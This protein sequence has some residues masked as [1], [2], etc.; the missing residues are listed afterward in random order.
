MKTLHTLMAVILCVAFVAWK[1]APLEAADATELP[2]LKIVPEDA[3]AIVVVSRLDRVDERLGKLGSE[4]QLPI[5]SLLPLLKSMSGVH[6]GLDEKSSAVL[7]I[8]PPAADGGSSV[9]VKLVPVSDYEKFLGQFH[10][11]TVADGIAEVILM[12]QPVVIGHK[13][14]FAVVASKTDRD[15]LKSVLASSRSLAPLV[16]PLAGWIGDHEI[17]F[18]A[19]PKGVKQGTAFA[20]NG[21]RQVKEALANSNDPSVKMTTSSLELYE[22][23]LEAAEKE[24]GELALGARI[25]NDGGLHLDI[26]ALF[27]AGGS[28]A[29]AGQSLEHPEGARLA[30][31]PNGPF[32]M[33]FDGPMPKAFSKN[34]LNLS[35]DMINTMSKTA[36]GKELNADQAK[37]LNDLMDKSMRNIRSMSMAMGAPKPGGS[38]Y[39]NTAAVMKV[40]DARKYIDDYQD[41]MAK[42][43][44]LLTASGVRMP[45][46]QEV[47][48]VKIDGDDAIQLTMDLAAMFNGMPQNPASKK[49]LDLMFGPG[50]KMTAYLAPI[51]EATVAMSY[52]N[53]DNIARIKAACKN[54]TSSLSA[55]SQ[56]AKT[57]A[58]LPEKA[59]WVGYVSPQGFMDFIIAAMKAAAP[60]GATVPPLTAFPETPPIGIGA[61]LS[62]QGFDLQVVVPGATVKG[63][64]SYIRQM[65][66]LGPPP[67]SAPPKE[68]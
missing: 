52:I 21:L 9:L 46:V 63:L 18:V 10:P 8:L 48:K 7:A 16:A 62:G 54:P 33:A 14:D 42:M 36:G 44:D 68:S 47:K 55:D 66:Q 26:R 64:G 3:L 45:F 41:L 24:V 30:C 49:M 43:N 31:L 39:S 56:L 38:M 53:P 32:M 67:Q 50:G 11:M 40:K 12:G 58:L 6:E 22:S 15:A 1:G 34:L 29:T 20:R 65:R 60:P 28:L 19:M 25:D 5:P 27:V 35:V 61:E 51:D 17:S 59:Q 57:A 23:A 13:G 2:V 37:Q 4:M